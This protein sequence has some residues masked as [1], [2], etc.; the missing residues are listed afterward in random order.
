MYPCKLAML[1]VIALNTFSNPSNALQALREMDQSGGTPFLRGGPAC[2][3]TRLFLGSPD[4][5]F[6]ASYSAQRGRSSPMSCS[7][8]A[9][10]TPSPTPCDSDVLGWA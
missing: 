9:G 10:R 6:Q 8:S 3:D 7:A 1:V 2:G 4:F 5:S